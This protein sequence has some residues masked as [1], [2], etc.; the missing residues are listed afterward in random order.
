VPVME[1]MGL[2]LE[3]IYSHHGA[4]VGTEENT[5]SS[6]VCSVSELRVLRGEK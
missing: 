5:L 2:C 4:H 3:L 6:S 1:M